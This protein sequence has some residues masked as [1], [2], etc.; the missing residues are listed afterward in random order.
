MLPRETRT[1]IR[2]GIGGTTDAAHNTN[3]VVTSNIGDTTETV[4]TINGNTS[5]VVTTN[6]GGTTTTNSGGTIDTGETTDDT[7]PTHR[8][9]HP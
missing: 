4:V 9:G 7:P 1:I 3:T 2:K 5:T 8:S 6:K